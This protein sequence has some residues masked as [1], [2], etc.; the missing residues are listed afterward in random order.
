MRRAGVI[1]ALGAQL[2]MFGG[3]VTAAPAFAGGGGDGWQV[4]PL[5]PAFTEPADHCGFPNQ[6]TQDVADV[7]A[8]VLKTADGS[9][10]FLST[11]GNHC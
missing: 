3:V 10:I 7:F 6:G 11:G 5:P 9:T 4:L 1:V 8:K 2:G